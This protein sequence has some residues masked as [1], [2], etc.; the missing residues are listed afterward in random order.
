MKTLLKISA[1]LLGLIVLLIVA[2]FM[3][4]NTAF[5]K[6]SEAPDITIE[7]TSERVQR[8]AFLANN[9]YACMDCHS[10]RDYSRFAPSTISG[11]EGKGGNL[12]GT[13]NLGLPGDYYA[14]NLTPYNLGDWT[15][16]EIFRA[17][18]SGVTKDGKSMFPIMPYPNYAQADKEDIYDIIAYLRTL[19]PIV[20]DVP[21]SISAFP[22]TLI[23]NTIPADPDFSK[24]PDISDRVAYGKYL[25]TVASCADCHTP[26]D[27]QGQRLEGMD[28]AGGLDF[29]LQTG[30]TVYSANITPHPET[31]IG[32]WTEDQ[33]ITRFKQFEEPNNIVN[34][35]LI[36]DGAFNTEMPWRFYSKMSEDELSAI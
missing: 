5:P 21:E 36:A 31:G 15:D 32:S 8:G 12:F 1:I 6:V 29:N 9:I 13:A 23:I 26:I 22:M 2:V 17:I 16:G 25:V 7:R 27:D 33:F 18:T 34:T 30:I 3:Y 35:E 19:E 4:L 20:H 24:K 10:D 28:F 14:K 11:T